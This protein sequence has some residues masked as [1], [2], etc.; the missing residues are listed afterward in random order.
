MINKSVYVN[1]ENI[2]FPDL[3]FKIVSTWYLFKAVIGN[4][5]ESTFTIDSEHNKSHASINLFHNT[6]LKNEK[7]N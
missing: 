2:N 5:I 7:K 1:S 4:G 6:Q 3:R